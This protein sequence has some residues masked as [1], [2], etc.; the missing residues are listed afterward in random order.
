MNI[1]ID[2]NDMKQIF[3]EGDQRYRK[4]EDCNDIVEDQEEE[5]ISMRK[6]INKMQINIT[7]IVTRLNWLVGIASGVGGLFAAYLAKLIFGG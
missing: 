6:D 2:D 3:L 1:I 5:T 7:A 4:I